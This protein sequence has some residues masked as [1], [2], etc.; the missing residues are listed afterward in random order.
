MA[1]I[2]KMSV[3]IELKGILCCLAMSMPLLIF[4]GELSV[5]ADGAETL[6]FSSPE[7]VLSAESV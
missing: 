5:A 2:D 7:S 3:R 4:D 1:T 6:H